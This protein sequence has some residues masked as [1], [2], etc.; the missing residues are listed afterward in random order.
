MGEVKLV[1]AVCPKCGASLR[2]P[3]DLKKAHC[4]YCGT[5]VIVS[6]ALTKQKIQCTICKGT[7]RLDACP[8]CHGTGKCSW[9]MT[10]QVY[11]GFNQ[12]MIVAHCSDGGCSAC[13]GSGRMLLS[14]CPACGGTGRCPECR[15]STKCITCHGVSMLPNPAGTIICKTC[16]GD[17]IIDPGDIEVPTLT[18]CPSCDSPWPTD[19]VFCPRCGQPRN[20]PRCGLVWKSGTAFCSNCGFKKGSRA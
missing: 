13:G 2:L 15:G 1:P 16:G 11:S 6:E 10:A 7:G 14:T 18:T 8:A 9:S 5:E 4:T 3:E 19:G 17:G 12:T 20:C